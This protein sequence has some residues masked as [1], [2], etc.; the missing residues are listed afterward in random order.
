MTRYAGIR[1]AATDK[2]GGRP[3]P[4]PLHVEHDGRPLAFRHA[5]AFPAQRFDYSE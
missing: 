5:G 4:S 1:L 3:R 2:K